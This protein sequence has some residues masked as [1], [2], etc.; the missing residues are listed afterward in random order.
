MHTTLV[1][2][3]YLPPLALPTPPERSIVKS[4]MSGDGVQNA[5]QLP[6]C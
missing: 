6:G 4:R 3:L 1:Q 5:Y 2:T